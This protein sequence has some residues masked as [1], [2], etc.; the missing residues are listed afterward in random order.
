MNMYVPARI[1]GCVAERGEARPRIRLRALFVL[2]VRGGL[3]CRF[4]RWGL[5]F[6]VSPAHIEGWEES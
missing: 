1:F 5:G 6:R 4:Y 2:N 3:L